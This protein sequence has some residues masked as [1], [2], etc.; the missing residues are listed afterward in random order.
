MRGAAVVCALALA[1]AA[2]S[3]LAP[4]APGY[5]A[6]AWLVWGREVAALDLDTVEGPAFKPL[7]VAVTALLSP[8]GSAAPELWLVVA[9][10]GA[11]VAVVLG[12]RVAW[13][14]GGRSP[15]A[16]AG[17]AAAVALTGGWWW[18]M[19]T[20]GSEPLFTALVLGAID[21]RLSGRDGRALA[22][23]TAA[24]L[25]RPELWPF[26]G[27]YG[28]WLWLRSPRL[29]PWLAVVAVALPAIWF[30]AELWGS[31]DAMRSSQ[32]A[33]VVEAGA[34]AT[35]A[36]PLAAA[37]A[38]AAAAAFWPSLTAALALLAGRRRIARSTRLRRFMAGRLA[39]RPGAALA[40]TAGGLAWVALVAVMAEMG[41]SGEARYAIPGLAV[42]GAGAAAGLGLLAREPPGRAV[43]AL[44]ALGA[45]VFTGARV[46]G[47]AGDVRRSFDDARL[48]ASLDRAVTAAG[49]R[50]ALLRCGRPVLGERRGPAAAWALRVHRRAVAFDTTGGGAVLR[51]TLR[52][53]A[54]LTPAAPRRG[55][56][57]ARNERWEIWAC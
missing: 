28:L 15:W 34:P 37:L 21:Q 48:Y 50:D 55:S 14:L 2:L 47:H 4:S 29:R 19:A 26:L 24:A 16:A 5:D 49:G 20:G 17:G 23:A 25:L 36:R 57:V 18:Q 33:Q 1:A 56:V 35:A 53:E 45:V 38:D 44:L 52:P 40:V 43:I 13:R 9:R 3:L 42:A 10:A 12:G 31:G 22:L 46:A 27:I 8:A 32:R 41:Y 54:P 39:L 51:S 6:W 7:A 30:G 11:L